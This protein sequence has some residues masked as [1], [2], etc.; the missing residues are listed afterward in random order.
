MY[1]SIKNVVFDL[2][3]YLVAV[4]VEVDDGLLIFRHEL[5]DPR[6]LY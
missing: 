3:K 2:V 4:G 5:S 1:I 6:E